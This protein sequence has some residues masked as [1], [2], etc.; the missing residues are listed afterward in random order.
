MNRPLF[1]RRLPP[2]VMPIALVVAWWAVMVVNAVCT[3]YFLAVRWLAY[4]AASLLWIV[5]LTI[6]RAVLL[7]TCGLR[8]QERQQ[9]ARVS[10]A[11][12][13][14]D[15]IADYAPPSALQ[16]SMYEGRVCALCGLSFGEG[17]HFIMDGF[18]Y[19]EFE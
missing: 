10:V 2:G 3:G 5:N 14:D 13:L 11:L 12:L 9:R 6:Q 15:G 8:Q 18:N 1:L 4:A 19:H 7:A 16:S 17:K